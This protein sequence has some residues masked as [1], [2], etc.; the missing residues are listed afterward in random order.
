MN[1]HTPVDLSLYEDT[2]RLRFVSR[3]AGKMVIDRLNVLEHTARV[4]VLCRILMDNIIVNSRPLPIEV[5]SHVYEYAQVHDLEE[6][7][8]GD[9]PHSAKMDY[10]QLK[11][12]LKVV[13]ERVI[14]QYWE[15]DDTRGLKTLVTTIVKCADCID[16]TREATNEIEVGNTK[17]EMMLVRSRLST[18]LVN[19]R[20]GLNQDI[21]KYSAGMSQ[22]LSHDRAAV[23]DT[24]VEERLINLCFA[25]E[26]I[27]VA[28][29]L[30]ES[31]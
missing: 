9:V 31:V 27:N 19:M 2:D 22:V 16:C 18:V 17:F 4:S 6:A 25:V 11:A 3:W 5:R 8:T 7:F 24:L 29:K 12:E 14:S 21:A 23:P 15:C 13:S 28:L 1:N 30:M 20:V 10:P 26:S